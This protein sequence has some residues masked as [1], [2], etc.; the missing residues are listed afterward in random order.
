MSITITDTML[1][2]SIIAISPAIL[3]I[4][5]FIHEA[6]MDK[7]HIRLMIRTFFLGSLAIIPVYI[8]NYIS[9][10]LFNFDIQYFLETNDIKESILYVFLGCVMIATI[11]EYSK[12]II[13]R[14]VD[15]N[16]KEFTSIVDG[17]EFAVACGLGFAFIEN[18]IYFIDIHTMVG[19]VTSELAYA[20]VGRSVLSMLA[21]AVFSGIFG[22]Y[23]G[24]AKVLNLHYRR[25]NVKNR[26]YG[27][28]LLHGLRVR[29][30]RFKYLL[31]S[32]NLHHE[33]DEYFK[34]KELVAEGLLI[35]IF[36]HTLYNFFV[37]RNLAWVSVILIAA[38]FYIV[39]H[40]VKLHNKKDVHHFE[41]QGISHS[42]SQ[43]S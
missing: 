42:H 20:I 7:Q 25:V 6:R 18:A 41:I 2:L 35:A 37:M 24:R 5:Y 15:W 4:W 14:E 8:L 13:V 34:E 36:L 23:Y 17:I 26:S 22:Y 16:K 30:L 27:F 1:F 38:E 28:H 10:K 11:E 29:L 31:Q 43:N 19:N 3:F 12:S 40:E 39:I 33:V 9:F 21:H 32:K